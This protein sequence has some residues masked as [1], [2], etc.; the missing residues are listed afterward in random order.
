[1][2]TK[3]SL[4]FASL[5]MIFS[6]TSTMIYPVKASPSGT[7]SPA[8]NMAIVRGGRHTATLLSDG[9]V[10]V[11]GGLAELT[12]GVVST[13]DSAEL[14][15]PNTNSWSTTGS[16]SIPRSRH[17]ATRLLDGRVLVAGGRL[18][19]ASLATAELYDP[20]TGTWGPTGSMA[21]ARDNFR[22]VLLSDGKVLVM[23]GVSANPNGPLVQKT[24]EI[25]D[26]QTGSWS[27]TDKMANARFGH[28]AILL[29]DGRVLASGGAN[30]A[31]HCVFMPTA[32]IY[33]PRYEKWSNISPMG[34]ARGF[35]ISALLPDGRL[36]IGGGWALPACF[37]A[38]GSTEVYDPVTNRWN[39]TGNMNAARG[40]L[41]FQS[42]DAQLLDGRVLVS[43]GF[44]E[45]FAPLSASELYDPSTGVWNA[46]VDMSTA[47]VD[48]TTTRLADGR[49]LV[50]GGFDANFMDLATAE[51]YTP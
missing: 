22:A 27:E 20:E 6:T 21:I 45:D 40:A 41:A 1:M 28:D 46:T 47:R 50:V 38:T 48:H 10:L 42:T 9:R 25:F 12:P 8:G 13:L 44:S 2:K 35:H 34:A 51:I 36:L 17:S 16:M 26:P 19:G 32:E 39:F 24:A 3:F 49:M 7:W 37:T 31:G 43:G 4:I 14:Y 30:S 5:L 29:P 23:G 11:V 15:D 18:K 33:D